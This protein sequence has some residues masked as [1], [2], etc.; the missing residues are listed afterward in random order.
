MGSSDDTTLFSVFLLFI[1][2]CRAGTWLF[3]ASGVCLLETRILEVYV[4]GWECV[5]SLGGQG[6]TTDEHQ[7]ALVAWFVKN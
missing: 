1:A 6:R 7:H 2:S 5:R 3:S 4:G